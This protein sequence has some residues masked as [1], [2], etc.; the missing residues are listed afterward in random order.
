MSLAVD[1]G[2]AMEVDPHLPLSDHSPVEEVHLP[3]R[4]GDS[5]FIQSK[6]VGAHKH[7]S[8][9]S[10]GQSELKRRSA[11]VHAC[12]HRGAWT[13]AH[14]CEEASKAVRR[15]HRRALQAHGS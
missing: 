11:P 4:S 7:T 6:S 14:M 12:R 3:D 9:Q 1:G 13:R 15:R 2:E 10:R 5:V 8:T